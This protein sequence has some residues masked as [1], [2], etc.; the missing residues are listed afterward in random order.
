MVKIN[1]INE[2]RV[3]KPRASKIAQKNS[4]K[5]VACNDSAG[6]KPIGSRKVVSLALN[7]DIFAQP[8]V[9]IINAEP[10][11][12]IKR[13]RSVPKEEEEKNSFFMER[14]FFVD[15][16]ILKINKKNT[17]ACYIRPLI[18]TITINKSILTHEKD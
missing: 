8:W 5:I 11:L 4:A 9:I 2:S 17:S 13:A 1:G 15:A 6:P 7:S 3:I 14:S 18:Q 12:K 16:Y 10:N